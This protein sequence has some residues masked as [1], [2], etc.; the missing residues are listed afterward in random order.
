MKP[1][2][3]EE[4]LG[5]TTEP[6]PSPSEPKVK[7]TAK[8]LAKAILAS[9]QYAESVRRRILADTLPAAVECRLYDYAY[10]KPVD[11]VEIK[12]TTE[13]LEDLSTDELM[14]RLE[15]LKL[16]TA[17]LGH[18]DGVVLGAMGDEPGPAVH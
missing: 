18:G 1:K 3:L 7:Q 17:A 4:A 10:G 6:E 14:A 8:Q 11:K 2:T 13:R 9:P 15:A 16:A 12:D 5:L